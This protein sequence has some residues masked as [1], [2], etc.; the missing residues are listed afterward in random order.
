MSDWRVPAEDGLAWEVPVDDAVSDAEPSFVN[1]V[2]GTATQALG[3]TARIGIEAAAGIP[4]LL[5]TPIRAAGNAIR[6]GTF[7]RTGGQAVADVLSLPEPAEGLATDVARAVAGV[8]G[9]VGAAK[10]LGMAA[11]PVVKGASTFLADNVALQTQAAI[12]AGIGSTVAREADLGPVGTFAA[13]LAGSLAVP[14]AVR[15]SRAMVEPALDIAATVGATAGSKWGTKRLATDAVERGLVTPNN[16]RAA[17]DAANNATEFVPGATPTMGEAVAEY[18]MKSAAIGSPRTAG[19]WITRLEKDLTG[20]RFVEDALTGNT[21]RIS[22]VIDDARTALDKTTTAMR[23]PVLS[24]VNKAGGVDSSRLLANLENLSMTPE[25]RGDAAMSRAVRIARRTVMTLDDNGKIN[26]KAIYATRK[27]FN[28]L[29]AKAAEATEGSATAKDYKKMG[30]IT[31]Q[32]QL[33]IDD[34]IEDVAGKVGMA[35]KWRAYLDTHFSGMKVIESHIERAEF[36]GEMAKQVKPLGSN[37]VP[38]EL[39]HPPTLL[40]RKMMLVNWGLR[41][42][43]SDANTPVVR[44]LTDRLADPAKFRELLQRPTKDPLSVLANEALRRGALASGVTSVLNSRSEQP[45]TPQE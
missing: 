25:I 18:N 2:I 37:V 38:G 43:G 11:S 4:D 7:P 12:G 6:P 23:E 15:A 16:I 14:G 41:L 20:A 5:A 36:A 17:R 39:P 33:A 28:K 45:T 22:A 19:G 3:Q 44:D 34:A 24:A 29:V 42:M 10:V 31:H 27:S 9:G 13:Q 1:K 8:G 21:R 35:D 32:V 26:A 30:W 40:N